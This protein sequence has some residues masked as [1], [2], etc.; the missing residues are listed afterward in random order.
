MLI[1]AYI[2]HQKIKTVLIFFAKG[3]KEYSSYLGTPENTY[4]KYSPKTGKISEMK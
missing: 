4:F 1:I 2:F 3:E